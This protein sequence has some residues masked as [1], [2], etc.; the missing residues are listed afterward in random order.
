[1]AIINGCFCREGSTFNG[2]PVFVRDTSYIF[3]SANKWVIAESITDTSS[4]WQYYSDAA[5]FDPTNEGLR[6]NLGTLGAADPGFIT[7]DCP[8]S[9]SSD[10]SDSSSSTV[11]M[12]SSDS[13]SSPNLWTPIESDFLEAWY[14]ADDYSTI[15]ESSGLVSQWDDKSGNGFDAFPE[16][17]GQKPT[18]DATDSMMNDMPTIGHIGTSDSIGLRTNPDGVLWPPTSSGP[19]N[20]IILAVM[21][22]KTGVETSFVTSLCPF[23]YEIPSQADGKIAG[24]T[25]TADWL[26]FGSTW[27]QFIYRNGSTI[28][29]HDDALPMPATLWKFRNTNASKHNW[30]MGYKSDDGSKDW[31]GAFA[32]IIMLGE[33]DAE[34]ATLAE[35]QKFEGYLAWKWDGGVAG[36]LVGALPGG[37]P[38]KS[39]PPTN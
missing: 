11:G 9:S 18:Y 21:Y 1:M 38:Y 6:W 32:E 28:D 35:Q 27:A 15:T 3:W 23:S 22:H 31:Q 16:T 8:S 20:N 26:A 5:V 2:K 24:V 30:R 34:G 37:H 7:D 29:D 17:A 14:D 13:S 39:A 36:D 10:S 25:G 12:S 33:V 19:D 4:Q